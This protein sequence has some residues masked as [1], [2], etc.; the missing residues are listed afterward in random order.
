MQEN[1][2]KISK[3]LSLV[4]RHDP[5][6]IGI[7]LDECGWVSI[8]ELLEKAKLNH[9]Q[10]NLEQLNRVVETNDKKRFA[11]SEDGTKIRASQGHSIQVD[12]RLTET[13]PPTT[14]YH[15]TSTKFIDQI[16]NEGLKPMKRQ[17][18]HLSSD[19][20]TATKVG[21]RHGQPVVLTVH[22]ELLYQDGCNFYLSDN[23]VWL[24]S[25][26]DQKYLELQQS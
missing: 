12:L 13:K 16:M 2:I 15:G 24:T 25:F 7:Q 5:Q 6:K 18:V 10:I 23:G 26:V 4:L 1:D 14:L 22:S 20:I 19:I 3:F 8:E 11:I 21:Q 9:V 17:H